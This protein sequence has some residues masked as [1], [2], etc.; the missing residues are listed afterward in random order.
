MKLLAWVTGGTGEFTIRSTDTAY[1]D[2]KV[3]FTNTSPAWTSALTNTSLSV[4]DMDSNDG[5]PTAASP[6]WD[7]V[8]IGFR[9]L[10]S[11]TVY[12]AAAWMGEG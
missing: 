4:E 9:Q 7:D 5:R 3:T 2:E 10:T 11:G 6:Y 1:G 12:V 8:N